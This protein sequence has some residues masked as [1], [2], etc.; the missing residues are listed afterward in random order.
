MKVCNERVKAFVGMDPHR[1]PQ[2]VMMRE[3]SPEEIECECCQEPMVVTKTG[4]LGAD[5][6]LL[7]EACEKA[8]LAQ[9]PQGYRIVWVGAIGDMVCGPDLTEIIYGTIVQ[10]TSGRI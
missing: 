10:G 9:L 7:F 1:K 8:L 3:R 6:R 4:K 5:V 2:V